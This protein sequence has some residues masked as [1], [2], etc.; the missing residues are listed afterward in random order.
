MHF[1]EDLSVAK[2][3][4]EGLYHPRGV[5]LPPSDTATELSAYSTGNVTAYF[6]NITKPYIA[7]ENDINEELI[8]VTIGLNRRR[9]NLLK[10]DP[11]LVLKAADV[12]VQY[13]EELRQ[14]GYDGIV[15][16]NAVEGGTSFIAFDNDQIVRAY[17]KNKTFALGEKEGLGQVGLPYNGGCPRHWNCRS[18]EVPILKS[19]REMGV[20]MDE[21]EPST[22]AS[23]DGAVAAQMSFKDWLATRTAAQQDKIL[24]VGKADLWRE[25]KITLT[26]LLDMGG[27]PMTLEELRGKR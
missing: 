23:M 3:F 22:R 8:D 7:H 26:D 4:A 10:N 1:A 27:R 17:D 16:D 9:F 11:S 5:G 13:R 15:Y 14:K 25:G 20:D 2:R 18:I 19:W 24:G 12:A 6:L 21:F